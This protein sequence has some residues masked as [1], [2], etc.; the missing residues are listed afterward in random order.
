MIRKDVINNIPNKRK[1]DKIRKNISIYFGHENWNLVLNLMIG[2]RTSL[3]K[4]LYNETLTV[5]DFKM[6]HV[7]ELIH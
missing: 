5:K 6:R 3:K 4:L 1:N 7:E 2:I